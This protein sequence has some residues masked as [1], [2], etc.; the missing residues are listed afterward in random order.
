MPLAQEL[1]VPRHLG[2]DAGGS[3]PG[4]AF[5]E[6]LGGADRNGRLPHDQAWPGQPRRQRVDA[7]L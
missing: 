7:R 6:R 2:G 3:K 4:Q 5:G 1:G